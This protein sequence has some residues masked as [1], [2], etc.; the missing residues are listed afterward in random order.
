MRTSSMLLFHGN[1]SMLYLCG[2]TMIPENRIP[3]FRIVL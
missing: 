2:R 3:L 1:D